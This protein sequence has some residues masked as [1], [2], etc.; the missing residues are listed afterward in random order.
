MG[1]NRRLYHN[2]GMHILKDKYG[3]TEIF[4]YLYNISQNKASKAMFK[5][6]STMKRR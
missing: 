4:T 3:K 1:H 6:E 5:E 2:L